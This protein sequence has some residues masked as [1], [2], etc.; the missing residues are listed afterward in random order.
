MKDT[1]RDIFQAAADGAAAL[2]DKAGEGFVLA[3]TAAYLAGLEK[4]RKEAA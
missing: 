3:I 4:G 1:E 2:A